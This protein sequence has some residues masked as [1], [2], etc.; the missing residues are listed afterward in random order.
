M[1]EDTYPDTCISCGFL[2]FTA[3]REKGFHELE[4]DQRWDG[5]IAGPP[6]VTIRCFRRMAKLQSEIEDMERESKAAGGFLPDFR[7]HSE[8]YLA[9]RQVFIKPRPQC[10]ERRIWHPY[11]ES[12]DPRWHY[13][14]WRMSTLEE[15]RS[16]QERALHEAQIQI[17]ADHKAIAEAT[18]RDYERSDTQNRLFSCAFVCL[19]IIAILLALAPLTYPNGIPWLVHHAPWS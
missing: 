2:G 3:Q 1:Y 17:M 14:D 13:E 15:L 8:Y 10:A 19:A 16:A 18:R 5:R 9:M 12:L 7:G 6:S 4:A 11:I